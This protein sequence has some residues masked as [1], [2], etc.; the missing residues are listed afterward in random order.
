MKTTLKFIKQEGLLLLIFLLMILAFTNCKKTNNQPKIEDPTLIPAEPKGKMEGTYQW[1]AGDSA[2]ADLVLTTNVL[3]CQSCAYIGYDYY[4]SNLD[5][6]KS[7]QSYY[8]CPG[9]YK[10]DSL[11]FGYNNKT[12]KYVRKY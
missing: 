3:N 2:T 8:I 5:M 1:Y 7:G 12:F 4:Y 9:N 11:F 6:A 10:T